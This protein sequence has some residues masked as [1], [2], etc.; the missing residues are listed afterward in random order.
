MVST[1]TNRSVG[2]AGF[3]VYS[4]V[5][6][7]ALVSIVKLLRRSK[8]VLTTAGLKTA[9]FVLLC[10]GCELPRYIFLLL[11]GAYTSQE[12]YS[13]H[14]CANYWFY[15]SLSVVVLSLERS[16]GSTAVWLSLFDGAPR[17]AVSKTSKQSCFAY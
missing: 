4:V 9:C 15:T 2:I 1:A 8:V 16:Y 5:S 6:A 17:T 12:G 13:L 14:L 3:A 10:S 11:K 7:I